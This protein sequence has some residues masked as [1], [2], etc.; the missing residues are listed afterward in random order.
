MKKKRLAIIS[1]IV[2]IAAIAVV[3][4][5]NHNAN[6]NA[7]KSYSSIEE[8]NKASDFKLEHSDRLCGYTPT[9]YKANSSTIE[10]EFGEVGYIRKTL[11]VTDNSGNSEFNETSTKEVNGTKVT[12]MGKDKMVYLATWNQN[13]FAY[14]ISI[15]DEV[16]PG[17][18]E[19]E[20]LEYVEAT[21]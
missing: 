6:N 19:E 12:L 8:A 3:I 9:D 7:Q 5:I 10:V 2:L 20:M 18:S 14:T 13:N 17:V 16:A 4:V 21:F 1:I 15:N 11:G